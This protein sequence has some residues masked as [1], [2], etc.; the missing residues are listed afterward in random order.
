[1]ALNLAN[2]VNFGAGTQLTLG[3]TSDVAFGGVLSGNGSL[4][5]N[6]AGL[7]TLNNTNTFGGGLTLNGGG[8]VVGASG[9]LGT[10]ALAVNASTTLDAGTAVTLGMRSRWAR[11]SHSRCPAAMR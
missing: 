4:V 6:G 8:L 7:L 3:G 9:A 10:G 1:M 5:K 11:A 2:A